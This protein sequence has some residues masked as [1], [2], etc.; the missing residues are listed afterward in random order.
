MPVSLKDIAQSLNLSVAT[1]SRA[2][3]NQG[4]IS[5]KTRARVL[6]A[7]EQMHYRPNEAA[8]AL[9]EKSSHTIGIIVPDIGNEFYARMIKGAERVAWKAGYALLVMS[10][11]E[12]AEREQQTIRYMLDKRV[13]G[14][15]LALLEPQCPMF[16]EAVQ[17]GIP[18]AF[19]DNLPAI[20]ASFDS[21]VVD[22]RL[23]SY[24]MVKRLIGMGH[25]R[26]TM[27]TCESEETSTIQRRNGYLQAV[28]EAGLTPNVCTTSIFCRE[29]AATVMR[30][31]IESEE[32]PTAVFAVNNHMAYGAM[33]A[34]RAAHLSVP[35]D[36]SL[37]C[38]DAID[39]TG[40]MMP[41][42]TSINQPA[43]RFGAMAVGIL[44]R[45]LASP[46]EGVY[47]RLILEPEMQWGGSIAP[48]SEMNVRG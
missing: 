1:V 12:E 44:L 4:R 8:R 14:L 46:E 43:D 25:T 35:E 23:L 11:N 28:N 24:Q 18:I 42:L 6:K 48:V 20:N 16:E 47:E 19:V 10:S 37:C 33:D 7:M 40:L 45:K 30:N 34:L 22:N 26:I 3:N 38:F 31:L 29:Q 13:A 27:L 39:S 36:M 32:R 41:Q 9:R 15:V 21:V 2:L 17:Y 5:P